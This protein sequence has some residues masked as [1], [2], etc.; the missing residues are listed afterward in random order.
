MAIATAVSAASTVLSGLSQ[1]EAASYGAQVARNNAKVAQQNEAH[2][3]AA[4]VAQTEQAGLRARSKLAGV[5]AGIAAN[6]ID[7]NSGSAA[8]VQT[9]QRME[10][11]LDQATVANNAAVEAYGYRTQALDYQAQSKLEQSQAVSDIFQAALG[12][13]GKV[14]GGSDI[15]PSAPLSGSV[16]SPGLPSVQGLDTSV[17]GLDPGVGNPTLMEQSPPVSDIY[18]WMQGG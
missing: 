12:S 9:T 2:V 8:D 10:G 14:A 5:R 11:A 1:A 3:A 17:G 6:N 16:A 7:V 18:A 13:A 4:S 15:A